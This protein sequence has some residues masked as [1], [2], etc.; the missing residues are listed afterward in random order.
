MTPPPPDEELDVPELLTSRA[1]PPTATTCPSGP[2]VRDW[3]NR[4]YII[5]FIHIPVRIDR[6][7]QT[8]DNGGVVM[9]ENV[10][11]VDAGPRRVKSTKKTIKIYTFSTKNVLKKVTGK[12]QDMIL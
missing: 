8:C 1:F 4:E 6:W 2:G 7:T 12:I 10:E 11:S 9:N 5:F 3:P